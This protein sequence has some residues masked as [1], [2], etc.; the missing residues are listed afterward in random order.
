VKRCV[1]IN[2]GLGGKKYENLGILEIVTMDKKWSP[3]GGLNMK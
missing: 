2:G 1:I 3:S